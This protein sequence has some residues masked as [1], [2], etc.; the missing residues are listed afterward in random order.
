MN[1]YLIQY[2]D[3]AI[4]KVVVC[5]VDSY[6]VGTGLDALIDKRAKPSPQNFFAIFTPSLNDNPPAAIMLREVCVSE[7]S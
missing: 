7:I 4:L 2:F 6:R 5:S 1:L 3:Q